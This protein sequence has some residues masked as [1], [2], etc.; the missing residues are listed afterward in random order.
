MWAPEERLRTVSSAP[1][2]AKPCGT[3]DGAAQSEE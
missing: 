2:T 1:N 3:L